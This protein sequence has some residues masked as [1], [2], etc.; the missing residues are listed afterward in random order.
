[1]I[2][3]GAFSRQESSFQSHGS[4]CRGTLFLPEGETAPPLVVMAHGFAAERCFGLP[5]YAER[6]AKAGLAVFFFDYRNFGESRGEPR[7]WVSP[8]R[9]LQDWQ[10]ALE[11]VRAF[12]GIT[13]P[14][15]GLWGSSLSGAHVIVTAAKDGRVSAVS[16]QVPFVD[17]LR[18]MGSLGVGYLTRAVAAGLRDL[19]TV[20]GRRKP[21]RVPVVGDP[22]TFAV[23]NRPDSRS[24][25]LA[26]VPETS[27]WENSCPAR[28]FLS[29]MTYRP[30]SFASRLSCPALVIL[31]EQDSLIPATAVGRMA[32]RMTKGTLVRIPVGHFDVYRGEPFEQCVGLQ[33]EFFLRHLREG[34]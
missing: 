14:R 24:G 31:A 4:L 5:A 27:S 23:M 26:L 17:D 22:G 12:P 9:H 33:T 11:H 29:M 30:S 7:N 20:P 28:V 16:A 6:F 2:P 18:S 15:I 25:Y 10:N 19:A 8:S 3:S 32:A 1:M 21:Y 34:V 13:F